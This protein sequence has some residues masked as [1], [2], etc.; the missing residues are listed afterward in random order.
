MGATASRGRATGVSGSH[1]KDVLKEFRLSAPTAAVVG[2]GMA[3]VHVAYELAQMGFAVTVFERLPQ[4]AAGSTSSGIPFVGVGIAQPHLHGMSIWKQVFKGMLWPWSCPDVIVRDGLLQSIFSPET[5]LWLRARRRTL[6]DGKDIVTYSNHLS[7]LSRDTVVSMASKHPSLRQHLGAPGIHL[8]R[9]ADGEAKGG[10]V[11]TAHPDPRWID[12]VGWTRAVAELLRSQ[13]N[14]KFCLNHQVDSL[15]VKFRNNTEMIS[16][17]NISTMVSDAE[18]GTTEVTTPEV[19]HQNFDVVVLAAGADTG[20]LS[21]GSLRLPILPLS[22][23]SVRFD[24]PSPPLRKS[25]DQLIP[26]PSPSVSSA[27]VLKELRAKANLF[28]YLLPE[29]DSRPRSYHLNGL[30]STDVTFQSFLFK[31]QRLDARKKWLRRLCAYVNAFHDID[32]ASHAPWE[33][34][35]P[36]L[37]PMEDLAS[38]A[39]VTRYQIGLSPDGVPLVDY[40]GGFFNTFVCAGFGS[41]TADLAPGAAV[42][43]AALV[44]HQAQELLTEQRAVAEESQMDRHH[45]PQPHLAEAERELQEV[46]NG[47][48]PAR[49][50]TPQTKPSSECL[51]ITQVT[52]NP[53]GTGR[54]DR[55]LPQRVS[56]DGPQPRSPLHVFYDMEDTFVRHAEPLIKSFNNLVVALTQFSVVP[57]ALR[58][59]LMAHFY[60]PDPLSQ[61]E[62]EERR[63]MGEELRRIIA[64]HEGCVSGDVPGADNSNSGP[65]IEVDWVERSRQDREAMERHAREFFTEKRK[66]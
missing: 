4:V 29:R 64:A 38:T 18:R 8:Q 39:S 33:M 24:N 20:A 34:Q 63:H 36:D 23:V 32:L 13:Y 61:E 27:P 5:H 25:L 46:W 6:M 15:N 54:F 48:L 14:V 59:V 65:P 47:V 50:G 51:S 53:Y 31:E 66:V 56:K 17:L 57:S 26:S 35:D 37:H 42:V 49:Y 16:S 43:L 11:L 21:R 30:L 44:N 7:K 41:R 58:A 22:S 62:I 60:E 12:P 1:E 2:A 28:G 45:L 9:E 19:L 52:S 10:E 55:V 3:G 40:Y